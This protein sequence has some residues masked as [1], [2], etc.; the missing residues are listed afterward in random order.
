[1]KNFPFIAL[2]FLVLVLGCSSASENSENT[3]SPVKTTSIEE[4]IVSLDTKTLPEADNI[5]V[6]RVRYLLDYLAARTAS[7][8]EEIAETANKSIQIVENNIGRRYTIQQF[9]EASRELIDQWEA[10]EK[11]KKGK[12]EKPAYE[13]IAGGIIL[14][15]K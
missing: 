12:Y 13:L 10:K 4:M 11:K 3:K 14:S 15:L 7:S 5:D 1:M 6:K 8:R 2:V 9:L